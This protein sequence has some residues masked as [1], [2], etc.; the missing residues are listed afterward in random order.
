MAFSIN[1]NIASMQAQEYLRM[2]SEFQSKTINRVTSGLRIVAAGDDAA[3]LAIANSFRSDQAVLSQG[4]RNA[5]DGLATLQTI[6]GGISNI[7][8]LLDR[9][10]TLATQSAS[11]TFNGNRSVLN[12]EF[13][14]VMEEI[15]RQAQAIGLNTDGKFAKELKV[16]LGGG[17]TA[18]GETIG[19]DAITNG[20]VSVDLSSSTVDTRSLGLKSY[21]ATGGFDL[22]STSITSV[23]AILADASNTAGTAT[24]QFYGPGFGS[25]S[26]PISVDV[27][28]SGVVDT[29]TLKEAI[30]RAV[31]G[32]TVTTPAGQA[33][34]DAGIK[35]SVNTDGKLVFSSN[36][37]AFSVQ[38]GND[39]AAAFMGAVSSGTSGDTTAA[40]N[41][42]ESEGVQ[43]VIKADGSG[44][45]G[46][47][48]M[49]DGT[50]VI[51]LTSTD[52]AGDAH[53]LAITLTSGSTGASL[54]AA[55]SHIND[56]LQ[57]SNDGELQKIV[58][59]Q[60]GTAALKFLGTNRSFSITLGVE[61][62]A[63]PNQGIGGA[64]DQN[65]IVDSTGYGMAAS[66][67]IGTKENAEAAV[68][69]LANAVVSLGE[70]QAVIGKGQNQ[71][72]F[73]VSL[74]STQLTNLA[75]SESRIRDA[76]LALEAAN[77]TKA[78][79][80]QQAGIAALAQA[81]SAPQAVLSLLRG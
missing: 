41:F 12:T 62:G 3:G 79:L 35:A 48:N 75:A 38:G 78:Q 36:S 4:I 74:A 14:S 30:N 51:T 42:G 47:V 69:S 32:Y 24:F 27:N 26:S 17:R 54:A 43:Q 18:A 40:A 73:A 72:N 5:N 19:A 61:G 66:S 68:T 63:T 6:D 11:G 49:G 1:T 71:F 13:K 56:S 15:D 8:K 22:R 58:A 53:S 52:A 77:L 16:F 67:D 33:F 80:L 64:T 59:V 65:K 81:N 76:D 9:A 28:M 7:S 25:Y 50:Q 57:N 23:A 44:S 31:E 45:L 21:A 55:L 70:A 37:V 29:N 46:W 34:K 60:D 10:R 39:T 2:T 20:S